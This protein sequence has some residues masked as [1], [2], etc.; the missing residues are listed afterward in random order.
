VAGIGADTV[1]C[2]EH[3]HVEVQRAS[4]FY[5]SWLFSNDFLGGGRFLRGGGRFLR[6]GGRFLGGG[7]RFLRGGGSFLRGGGRFLGGGGRFL[8]GGGRF[9]S[10]GGR[11]LSR[12]WFLG[13]SIFLLLA[14]LSL[15]LLTS[16]TE[17]ECID[18]CNKQEGGRR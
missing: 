10:G 11:F 4:L 3:L 9:L 17:A 18:A 15:S 7:G 8:R 12:S 6:G 16:I 14:I 5:G 2:I 1:D 13:K